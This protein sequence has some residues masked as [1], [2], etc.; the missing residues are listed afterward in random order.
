MRHAKVKKHQVVVVFLKS[1]DAGKPVF[2]RVDLQP[3]ALEQPC[4]HQQ[5]HRR[6]VDQKNARLRGEKRRPSRLAL[7]LRGRRGKRIERAELLLPDDALAQRK[8]EARALAVVALCLQRAAHQSKQA[9]GDRERELRSAGMPGAFRVKRVEAGEQAVQ[10][11][12]ADADPCVRNGYREIGRACPHALR[13]DAEPYAALLGVFDRVV[14]KAGEDL[15]DTP[16]VAEQPCGQP[17]SRVNAQ[18][19]S[20]FRGAAADRLQHIRQKSGKIIRSGGELKLSR[21]QLGIVQNIVDG[22]QQAVAR[23]LYVVGIAQHVRVDALPTDHLVHAENAGDGRAELV[24]HGGEKRRFR[25]VRAFG[26]GKRLTQRAALLLQGTVFRDVGDEYKENAAVC[27]RLGI[28]PVVV[29]PANGAVPAEDAVFHMVDTAVA[30]RDLLRDGSGDGV[31]ILRMH[32]AAEGEAGQRAEFRRV[33]AAEY[34]DAGAVDVQKPL[35]VS[36]LIDKE[37][38]GHVCPDQLHIRHGLVIPLKSAVRHC[39]RLPVVC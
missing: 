2:R 29:H 16:F 18:R 36:R 10:F 20:L 24:S 19:E 4:D 13:T 26:G 8:E 25:A 21:L 31:V 37:P 22:C 15:L 27:F 7:R 33:R 1:P 5:V 34:F 30:R 14:Q 39:E 11:V 32:H 12:R 17:R 35:R 23:L 9:V 28:V 6:I 38:A 3:C